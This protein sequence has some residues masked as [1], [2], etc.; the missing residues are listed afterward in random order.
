MKDHEQEFLLGVDVGNT[1]THALISDFSG[2]VVGFGIAGCG[3][4]EVIGVEGFESVLNKV[5]DEAIYDGRIERD[6]IAGMGFGVAGYDWPSEKPII[7]KAIDS[8]GISSPYDYVND[9]VIGL[10]A[11]TS[12]GWGVAVDAGTG[13]NVRGR[14]KNGRMGRITGNSV[15]F[16]ELGGA[17]EIV[18]QAMIAA[19][20]AWTQRGPKTK[21]TQMLLDYAEV[22]NQ[23]TLI[24][25]LA[26]GKLNLPPFLAINVFQLAAEGD[27]V[28]KK[29]IKH[30]AHELA[31]NTNAVIRQL[32]IQK[33]VFEVVLIGSIF[34]AGEIF[35]KP[36][37]QTVRKFAPGAELVELRVPPVIG[38]VLLAAETMGCKP[39]AIRKNLI[40]SAEKLFSIAGN[41]NQ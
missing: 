2:E 34:Q 10:I 30:S 15:R 41:E 39:D 4:H 21:I 28:A 5:V 7:E 12:H 27:S 40:Q 26:T 38:A 13:N 11:G 16:G 19:T 29:I 20:Y 36:F 6:Q 17:S 1:K 23:D 3:N 22:E 37:Q 14:D 25:L 35:I 31:L 32:G 9:A 8:L 24:E 33:S 18:W